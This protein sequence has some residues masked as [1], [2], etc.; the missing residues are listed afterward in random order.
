MPAALD[1]GLAPILCVGETE[2]ERDADET[3]RKLRQQINEDLAG[4]PAE[5]LARGRD[6]LRADL[7]D[8]H[9]P[10]SR[11]RSRRRRR[12]RFIRALVAGRDEAAA[13]RVRILYGGSVKPENAAEL[14]ALP[15]VDGAL[16][17]GASLDAESFAEIA[18]A[19]R[20]AMSAAA[21]GPRALPAARRACLVVLDGWGLAE[22]GPGQRRLAR[23]HAGLRRAVGALPAHAR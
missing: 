2:E 6:R 11:R 23:A 16:V 21:P 14:L 3:E 8:R 22:P 4:V 17:G 1:A 20:G 9:R 10:A 7:G 19:A 18:A 12:S 15:D 5:R 13:E